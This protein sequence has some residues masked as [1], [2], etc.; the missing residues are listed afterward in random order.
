VGQALAILP[1]ISRSGSTISAGL[2]LGVK[3]SVAAE[4]SFLLAVPAIG[5]AA[6]LSFDDLMALPPDLVG[7]YMV[8]LAVSFLV[9]LG[10]VHLVL[11][12][13]RRGKFEYFAYYCFAAGAFGL[14]LFL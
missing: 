1:G 4:F 7:Q 9:A 5:G 13:I 10:A 11:E 2:L 3:P 12:S 14:Y 8:G 6:L